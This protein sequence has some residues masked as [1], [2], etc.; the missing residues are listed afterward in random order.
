M[1]AGYEERRLMRSSHLCGRHRTCNS[2]FA[3]ASSLCIVILDNYL[4]SARIG[5]S[6]FDEIWLPDRSF[7]DV[8]LPVSQDWV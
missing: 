4:Y 6:E 8:G 5:S 7:P 3:R 1:A 2:G